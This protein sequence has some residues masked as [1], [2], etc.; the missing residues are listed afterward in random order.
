MRKRVIFWVAAI[1]AWAPFAALF[2]IGA[3]FLLPG[4]AALGGVYAGVLVRNVLGSVAHARVLS[5]ESPEDTQNHSR[6]GASRTN[7]LDSLRQV[8][9]TAVPETSL[10][11]SLNCLSD[12]ESDLRDS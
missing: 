10:E 8:F 9:H 5:Q 1:A 6:P 4:A 7:A 2:L 12:S 3:G 11:S